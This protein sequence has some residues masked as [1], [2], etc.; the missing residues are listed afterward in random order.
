[1]ILEAE[2]TGADSDPQQI[3][4]QDWAKHPEVAF[5][6]FAPEPFILSDLLPTAGQPPKATTFSGDLWRN[7]LEKPETDPVEMASSSYLRVVV[8]Q[9]M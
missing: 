6:T 8:A 4:Q 7:H 2:L 3:L 9:S 5:Y 1:M